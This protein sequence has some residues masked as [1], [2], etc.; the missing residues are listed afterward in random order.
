MTRRTVRVVMIWRFFSLWKRA[1]PLIAMLLDSV[2]PEVKTI[3]LGS[4]PMRVAISWNKF[5]GK[6]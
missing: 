2:A 6:D 1:T 3:S 4:A 5:R